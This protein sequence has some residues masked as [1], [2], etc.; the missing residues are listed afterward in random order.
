MAMRIEEYCDVSNGALVLRERLQDHIRR[1]IL[2][3]DPVMNR[4]LDMLDRLGPSN[5]PLTIHGESGCGK[6][7]IVR[8]AHQASGREGKP[9]LKI[10]CAYLPE[11]QIACELFGNGSGAPGLLN[12]AA[13]GSLYI[14]NIN[15]LSPQTQYQL[16]EQ[17]N[18]IAKQPNDIRFITCL[19]D[20]GREHG[21]IEQLMYYFNSM[22]FSIPPLRQRQADI[23]L[24]TMQQL[25][26]IY[27]EYRVERAVSPKVMTA[28][29]A[30]DWPGN[31]RQLTKVIDRMAFMSD[32]TLMDSI[33]Q[34]ESCLSAHGQLHQMHSAPEQCPKEKP[35]KELV[36]DYEVMII[37]QRIERYGSL[38]KA[39]A[40]LG[41]SHSALSS[42]L[43]KYYAS[44]VSEEDTF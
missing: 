38:R 15:L 22:T 10:N 39:A 3:C 24:L 21:L 25:R 41:I 12:K 34:F 17:I 13:G 8:Y 36:L 28:M 4:Q 27:D 20:S 1:G 29:L 6:D 5:I 14:E 30:Y 44:R 40:A 23:L 7:G 32:T 33:S 11:A 2:T 9:F 19:Q 37:N 31:I 43:S 18:R 16:M 42:K 26:F 35:L